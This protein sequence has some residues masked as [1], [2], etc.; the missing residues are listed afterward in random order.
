MKWILAID[1]HGT[2]AGAVRF[3]SWLRKAVR[4]AEQEEFVAIQV[5]EERHLLAVLRYHHLSEVTAGARSAAQALIE[6]EGASDAIRE[7]AVVQGTEA[8]ET[9]AAARR[10]HGAGGIIIGRAA[11]TQSHAI[12]RLG[13]VAR[14]LLRS[15]AAP[16][17]VVPPDWQAARRRDGPIV[18][19]TNTDADSIEA[20][21]FGAAMAERL[22][23]DFKLLHVASIPEDFGAQHIPFISIEKLRQDYRADAEQGLSQ[24]IAAQGLERSRGVVVQG[25]VVESAIDFAEAQRSPI[26]V[27]GSRRLS[28]V[29]RT[30]LASTG[31]E[32]AA[33]APV[34]VAIVP[35]R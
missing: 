26:L 14:R 25:R 18:T 19:L 32:L 20:C 29:E 9:L 33:L 15:S 24:W 4:G 16:V 8:N 3:A 11:P 23:C 35:P 6:T 13:R 1:L 17:V 31:A 21:G 22:G 5:L 28:A 27:C 10:T 34:P 2:C 12:V 7:L 30:L